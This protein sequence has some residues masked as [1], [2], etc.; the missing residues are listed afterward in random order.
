M[1]KKEAFMMLVTGGV[2]SGEDFYEGRRKYVEDLAEIVKRQEVALIGPRRTG[3]TSI[4]QAYFEQ[5]ENGDERIP[6]YI[7][8]E[9]CSTPYDIITE[10]G[11]KLVEQK[12]GMKAIYANA[13][14]KANEWAT[15]V[16]KHFETVD[17]THE[18]GIGLKIKLRH[19]DEQKLEALGKE[20][21]DLCGSTDKPI[22]IAL[23][24]LP[25]AIWK[26][27]NETVGGSRDDRIKHTG[28]LLSFFRD[29]R[30]TNKSSGKLRMIYSG[31]INFAL[32]LKKL[33]FAED[34]NDLNHFS[35][36]FLSPE[37]TKDVAQQLIQGEKI[38]VED[39][40]MF[41]KV[42][43]EHFGYTTP[44]YVQ[45]YI[46]QLKNVI[47][48]KAPG[49]KLK[50]ED[51]ARAFQS[52]LSAE[53]GPEYFYRRIETY[54]LDN[55]QRILT[56]LKTI[57]NNQV[58]HQKPTSVDDLQGLLRDLKPLEIEDILRSLYMEDFFQLAENVS[59]DDVFKQSNKYQFSS[60]IIKAY[61]F[62]KLKNF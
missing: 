9:S 60:N 61:W 45:L 23:D 35:I 17:V 40:A 42:M 31:S 18:S 41:D 59:F 3:K 27:V 19:V 48:S 30:Q 56:I 37:E 33:G 4:I 53:F 36:P 54:H 24:E 34:H 62:K 5:L 6:L 47:R 7:N 57:A 13:T 39:K 58:N 38:E 52:V 46:E 11:K 20:L 12:G 29:I 14:E 55:K 26:Y 15:R 43:E 1:A 44:Y 21:K 16:K 8:L 2:P 28:I 50:A 51:M 22:V 49:Y 10:I 32:T 25:E